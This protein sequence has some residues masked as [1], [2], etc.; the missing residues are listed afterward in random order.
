MKKVFI[1][2][3]DGGPYK[4]IKGWVEKGELPFLSKMAREG[5][6]GKLK[7]VIPPFTMLAWPIIFTGKNPAKIGPFL[8]KSK[9]KG[10]DPEFFSEAQLINSSDIRTWSLWEWATHFGNKVGIMNVPMTYPPKKVNG[11]F[12]TGALTPKNAENFTY[13]ENLKEDIKK[14]IIDL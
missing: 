10:F 12:I 7:S 13:P 8:Y 5:A 3:F 2:G 4:E 1:I 11:F 14:Y 6:F 9:K